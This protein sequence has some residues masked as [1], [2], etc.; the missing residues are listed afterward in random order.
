M[1]QVHQSYT[2]TE[3]RC[4]VVSRWRHTST[5]Y[6]HLTLP[7]PFPFK[8]SSHADARH[9]EM[10]KESD[11][12]SRR[13]QYIVAARLLPQKMYL[14]T[15]QDTAKG[16]MHRSSAPPRLCLYFPRTVL[17]GLRRKCHRFQ[18]CLSSP[19]DCCPRLVRLMRPCC[20]EYR[21]LL[22]SGR[23]G[24]EPSSPLCSG[25]QLWDEGG[26]REGGRGDSVIGEG[27]R[28]S[29]QSD[30]GMTSRRRRMCTIYVFI[31]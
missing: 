3:E 15:K 4:V 9:K 30:E 21:L 22:S 13:E 16:K 24:I 27:E 11:W 6:S 17:R 19:Q 10:R 18:Q 14:P 5:L 2:G 8:R 23:L 20:L 1:R 26:G 31:G 7:G 28:S 25:W 12:A 29:G